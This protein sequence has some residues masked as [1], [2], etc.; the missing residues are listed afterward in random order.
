MSVGDV[1][2][3]NPRIWKGYAPFRMKVFWWLAGLEKILAIDH[4]R[5]RSWVNDYC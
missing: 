1:P 4:L 3:V 2:R 5:F